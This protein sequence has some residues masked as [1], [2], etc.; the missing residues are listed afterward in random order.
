MSIKQTTLKT[1]GFL[2]AAIHQG[3]QV[4]GAELGP[5]LI[6]GSGVFNLLQA[7]YGVGVKDLGDVAAL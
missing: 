3:Q 6:R 7:N 2:G 5:S 4:R 1:L